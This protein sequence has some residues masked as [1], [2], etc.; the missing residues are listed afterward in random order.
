MYTFKSTDAHASA[1]WLCTTQDTALSW[2][3][4]LLKP[5]RGQDNTG[6]QVDV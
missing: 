6:G 3:S 1:V 4:F 5:P 2:R